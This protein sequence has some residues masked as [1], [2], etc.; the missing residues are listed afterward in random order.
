MH[1][2]V[3]TSYAFALVIALSIGTISLVNWVND[4]IAVLDEASIT[5]QVAQ[6][7]SS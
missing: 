4:K 5:T 7:T 3:K 2:P 1:Q 6:V